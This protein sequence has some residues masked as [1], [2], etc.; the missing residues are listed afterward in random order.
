MNQNTQIVKLDVPTPAKVYKLS[1][2]RWNKESNKKEA[3]FYYV[4]YLESKVDGNHDEA[5][6]HKEE[7][8]DIF[9]HDLCLNAVTLARNNGIQAKIFSTVDE[10]KP[11][12]QV[13]GQEFDWI[14]KDMR[15]SD[16]AVPER[17]QRMAREINKAGINFDS[18]Y[19]AEPEEKFFPAPSPRPNRDPVLLGVLGRWLVE[20]GRWE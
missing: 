14:L 2:Y 9:F 11:T 7:I 19:I 3:F 12:M 16:Q 18:Y 6:E 8:K 1:G 4:R 10:L 13:K 15:I 5:E 20:I 17:F